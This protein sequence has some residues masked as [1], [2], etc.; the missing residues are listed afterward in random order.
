MKPAEKHKLIIR[1]TQEIVGKEEINKILKKRDLKVYLGTETSGRPHI[2]YFVPLM[3]IADF[4]NAGCEVTFLLAD[5]HAMVNDLKTPYELL[6]A[7]TKYY[8]TVL[9]AALKSVGADVKKLKF[10]RGS[11]FQL[12]KDYVTDVLRMASIASL[13]DCNKAASEVIRQSGS[14]KLGGFIYPI[15]QALDEEYLG[16]DAQYGGVDQRKILMFARQY[17]PKLEYKSRIEIMTPM[18][19]GLS[20]GK[21]SS[22]IGSSKID[23][24]DGEKVVHDKLR[25]AYCKAGD[26]KDNGVLAFVEHVIFVLKEDRKEAFVINRD[27]KFGGDLKYKKYK[28]LEKDFVAKKL[29]PLDLKNAVAREI[30]LLLKPVRKVMESKKKLIEEAYGK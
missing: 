7:R 25:S 8:K 11:S 22:S 4:L 21:M 15:M 10:V 5:L 9:T 30:D 28:D 29:H 23:L 17:L 24:L 13:H 20:G 1:N 14:P 2:G 3:K 6:D 27:K 12:K 18:I 19:P 16:V 26:V